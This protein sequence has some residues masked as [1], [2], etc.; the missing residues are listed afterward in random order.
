MKNFKNLLFLSVVTFFMVYSSKIIAQETTVD[1]NAGFLNEIIKGDTLTG[2]IRKHTTYILQRGQTYFINGSIANVGYAL[3]IKAENGSGT[4]PIIQNFNDA[5]GSYNTLVTAKADINLIN[6][7]FAGMGINSE[8]GLPD[9]TIPQSSQMVNCDVA[10]IVVNIDGCIFT[11][12]GTVF[13]RTA[14]GARKVQVLNSTFA[15]SCQISTTDPGNG[16]LFEFRDKTTDSVIVKNCTVVNLTDRIVRHLD[17][18]KK[19]TGWIQYIEFDHNTFINQMGVYGCFMFGDLKVGAKVTNN[20]FVNC[21]AMGFDSTST[22]FN[23]EAAVHG[24]FITSMLP[25]LYGYRYLFCDE[26]NDGISPQFQ[27]NNNIIM[28]NPEIKTLWA[29]YAPMTVEAPALSK[30]ITSLLTAGSTVPVT[31][32]FTALQ[33]IPM[34]P[35][36]LMTFL[37]TNSATGVTTTNTVDFDRHTNAYW[38]DSLD[39]SYTTNNSNFVGTDGLPVG[40]T[41]WNSKITG[42]EEEASLPANFALSNNY[43]NPFNP[44]TTI[45]FTVPEKASVT[46]KV[47]NMIGQEVVNLTNQEYAAG[48]H[49]INFNAAGLSSGVYICTMKAVGA[50]GKNF[51]ASQKM[52]LLK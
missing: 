17:G 51:M 26:P 35:K 39:C 12:C 24:E 15:N 33:N 16:R 46:M 52:T 5:S 31:V 34:W 10:G 7:Y 49:T 22:V 18:S 14:G 25:S 27:F 36:D 19:N 32:S 29:Q 44:S 21:Q 9:P 4:L 40:S 28:L 42:V 6:I 50:S 48:T 23:G 3:T 41:K 37:Y 47:Y 2:A 8:T 43:P 38:S 13:I 45:S 20:L 1:P 30:H 11:N